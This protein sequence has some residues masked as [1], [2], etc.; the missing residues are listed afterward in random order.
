MSLICT[1][2]NLQIIGLVCRKQSVGAL[3]RNISR[4]LALNSYR[5]ISNLLIKMKKIQLDDKR[6]LQL[7]YKDVEIIYDFKR[8][9]FYQISLN[10]KN[11][12]NIIEIQFFGFKNVQI[13]EKN[14][15]SKRKNLDIKK[16]SVIFMFLHLQM[17][18]QLSK[19]IKK[20]CVNPIFEVFN[21]FKFF[22]KKFSFKKIKL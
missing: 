12:N 7:S 21:N 4:N 22:R 6:S 10:S 16:S 2:L 8:Y 19:N 20:Q 15:S 13:F 3:R 14:P 18:F 17:L 1:Q 5:I 11:I 9:F